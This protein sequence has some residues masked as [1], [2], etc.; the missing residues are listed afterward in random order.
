M[1]I[2]N[3]V[4]RLLISRLN[5][6]HSLKKSCESDQSKHLL[7]TGFTHTSTHTHTHTH[8]HTDKH[9]HKMHKHNYTHT[10]AHTQKNKHKHTHIHTYTKAHTITYIHTQ[11]RILSRDFGAISRNLAFVTGLRQGNRCG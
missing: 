2:A 9:L 3:Q 5:D 1:F 6:R 10:Q 4:G 8:T 11:V 7:T